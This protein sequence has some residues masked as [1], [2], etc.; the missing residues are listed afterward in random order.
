MGELTLSLLPMVGMAAGG[1][2]LWG[3]MQMGCFRT[4]FPMIFAGLSAF[5]A[6]ADWPVGLWQSTPDRSGRVV[7]VRTK[8]CGAA[9]CGRVER[10]KDRHGYDTPSRVV[11]RKMLLDMLEQEDGSYLG[12]IW[13]PERNKILVARMQVRGNAM[14]LQNCDRDN[15]C[16]DAVWMRVR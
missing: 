13:E 11:G 12:R 2:S 4:L 8:P 14:H 15:T 7:H 6:A 9:I 10:A 16:N 1:V 3:V 5:P